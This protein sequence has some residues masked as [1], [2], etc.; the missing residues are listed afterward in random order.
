M[1]KIREIIPPQ[2]GYGYIA[3]LNG[4]RAASIIIVLLAHLDLLP[5]IPGGFGVT[6]FFFI[7]G[8]L[9]T[10][11]LIAEDEEFRQISLKR[12]YARRLIRLYPALIF[13]LFITTLAYTFLGYGVPGKLE[14]LS[15]L[16]YFNNIFQL[17]SQVKTETMLMPWW[18]LWSLSVEEHFYILFPVLVIFCRKN[19]NVLAM[20]LIGI[21]ITVFFLRLYIAF[22]TSLPIDEYNYLMTDARIDSLAWGC[23][24]AVALHFKNSLQKLNVLIGWI[25]TLFGFTA[26][27]AS[28]MFRDETY[29]YTVRFSI[30]GLAI[31]LMILNLYYWKYLAFA[32]KILE[33]KPLAIIGVISYPLY[34]WH[35]PIID[36]ITR[37]FGSGVFSQML[38]VALSFIL[39]F[40]SYYGIEKPFL[41]LRKRFGSKLVQK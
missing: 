21:I 26:L 13:M 3:G 5:Y 23:L 31:F 9:I 27:I 29:R 18:H 4:L 39:A 17:M 40:F 38:A 8:F 15:C 20:L 35:L 34:L 10:R 33:W 37:E 1:S 28:F 16:F 11:L 2:A 12:F 6:V 22:G 25:P 19:W 30:H 32:I 36:I 14:L 41:K 7:S 24:L